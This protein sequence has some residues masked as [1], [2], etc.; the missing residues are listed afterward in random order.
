M[1]KEILSREYQNLI[2]QEAYYPQPWQDEARDFLSS[3]LTPISHTI[4]LGD[5][6]LLCSSKLQSAQRDLSTASCMNY[7]M[8]QTGEFLTT[9]VVLK[10]QAALNSKVLLLIQD[11]QLISLQSVCHMFPK[12]LLILLNRSHLLLY[13]LM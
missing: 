4:D 13:P 2:Q 11:P 9:F 6:P 10:L 8:L 7:S 1:L 12:R 3:N 5:S